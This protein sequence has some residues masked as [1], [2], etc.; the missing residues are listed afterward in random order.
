MQ[1]DV[2]NLSFKSVSFLQ[3]RT[4]EYSRKIIKTK[5]NSGKK[6]KI[7]QHEAIQHKTKQTS[8]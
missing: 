4:A 8:N 2:T 1:K 7:K 5:S 6:L 3:G